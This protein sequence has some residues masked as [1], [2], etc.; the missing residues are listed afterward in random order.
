MFLDT[1]AVAMRDTGSGPRPLTVEQLITHEMAHA[2]FPSRIPSFE[3]LMNNN[4]PLKNIEER[5]AIN[6]TDTVS[7]QKGMFESSDGVVYRDNAGALSVYRGPGSIWR[8]E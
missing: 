1:T 4:S 7:A 2:I 8:L 6:L 5:G 3:E